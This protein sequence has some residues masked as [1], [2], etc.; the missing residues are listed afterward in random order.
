MAS[1]KSEHDPAV[2]ILYAAPANRTKSNVEVMLIAMDFRLHCLCSSFVSHFRVSI[3]QVSKLSSGH[4]RMYKGHGIHNKGL[5][6]I[7]MLF[8]VPFFFL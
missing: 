6:Y 7:L 8:S 1:G 3:F 4:T 5:K 2:S